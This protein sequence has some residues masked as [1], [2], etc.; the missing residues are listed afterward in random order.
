[1]VI[2]KRKITMSSLENC[3]ILQQWNA[4][5]SEERNCS[6][7]VLVRQVERKH[8]SSKEL[9]MRVYLARALAG[10]IGFCVNVL[11]MFVAQ[12]LQQVHALSD[13]G[14]MDVDGCVHWNSLV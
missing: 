5:N 3:F 12:V 4:S 1:V 7:T 10:L 2:G 14:I 6:S 11:H 8:N 13:N 9:W